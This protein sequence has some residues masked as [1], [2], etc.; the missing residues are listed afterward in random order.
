MSQTFQEVVEG[1]GLPDCCAM[2]PHWGSVYG[3]FD[4]LCDPEPPLDFLQQPLFLENMVREGPDDM[5]DEQEELAVQSA[6]FHKALV[7]AQL[8]PPPL[9]CP[10]KN[11]VFAS[12]WLVSHQMLHTYCHLARWRL[13]V[14]VGA[15]YLPR[16]VV[17]VGGGYGCMALVYDRISRSATRRGSVTYQLFDLPLF[18]ALQWYYLSHTLGE[19]KVTI[20]EAGDPVV[21]GKIN[22]TSLHSAEFLGRWEI[23]DIIL[24]DWAPELILSTWALSQTPPAVQDQIC[25]APW[26]RS[27]EHLLFAHQ[28]RSDTWPDA[29]WFTNSLPEDVVREPVGYGLEGHGY[30]FR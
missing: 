21:P 12:D 27:A 13:A 5:I 19:D 25:L 14:P 24:S 28:P 10:R 7:A 6:P 30:V 22:I 11:V 1:F 26:F 15:R 4:E 18:A 20:R 3:R 17:E 2:S 8:D 9:G 23:E 29:E 16:R